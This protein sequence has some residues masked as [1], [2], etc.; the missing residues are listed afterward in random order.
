[1]RPWT[2]HRDTVRDGDTE[3]EGDDSLWRFDRTIEERLL[4]TPDVIVNDRRLREVLNA[5]AH[6]LLAH[7]GWL[8]TRQLPSG[9]VWWPGL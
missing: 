5:P 8:K 9:F 6:M 1:M 4:S 2:S 7:Y 3:I